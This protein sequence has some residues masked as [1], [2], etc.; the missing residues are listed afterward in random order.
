M[1]LFQELENSQQLGHSDVSLAAIQ[2][3][4]GK[5]ADFYNNEKLKMAKPPLDVSIGHGYLV[6]PADEFF[7]ETVG[8]K[9]GQV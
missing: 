4:Y 3:A 9:T 8:F 6:R 1:E 2:K 7:N 5:K